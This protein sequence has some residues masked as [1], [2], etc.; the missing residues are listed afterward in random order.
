M[1]HDKG[2]S[3]QEKISN[4]QLLPSAIVENIVLL[5][6]KFVWIS[7]KD[8]GQDKWANLRVLYPG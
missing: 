4:P 3:S 5:V 7:R 6:P 8:M 1:G 2:L